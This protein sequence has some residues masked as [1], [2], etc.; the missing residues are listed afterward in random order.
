MS[1]QERALMDAIRDG[2]AK[3][4]AACPALKFLKVLN[5][6]R[7]QIGDGGAVALLESPHLRGPGE[8]S[9]DDNRKITEPVRRRIE[10]RFGPKDGDEP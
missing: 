3:A 5:L 6:N 10:G 9:L 7:N 4:L 8:L 2:G 1:P